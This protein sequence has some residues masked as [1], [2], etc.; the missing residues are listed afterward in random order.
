[1]DTYSDSLK[2]IKCRGV[3]IHNDKLLVVKHSGT[4]F[5]ALPGGHI[6]T[7]ENPKECVERELFE[8]FGVKPV[9]GRLLYISQ[10]DDPGKSFMEFFFEVT[11]IQDYLDTSKLKGTHSHELLDIFW[12]S[13]TDNID[14]LPRKFFE[15][16]KNGIMGTGDIQFIK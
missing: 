6:K 15:D 11:N 16:F 7:R 10:F 13:K 3:M 2:I 12:I 4:H 9:V 14:V 8:E 1:M 5:F